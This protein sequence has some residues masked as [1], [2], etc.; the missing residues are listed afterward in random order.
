MAALEGERHVQPG[1]RAQRGDVEPGVHHLDLAVHPEVRGCHLAGA[2]RDDLRLLG[3]IGKQA[4]GQLL[5]VE[6]DL[7]HVFLDAGDG[8][9]LML[10]ALDLHAGHRGPREGAEQRTPQGVPQR[11][12]ETALQRLD[13]KPAVM[14]ALPVFY[15]LDARGDGFCDHALTLQFK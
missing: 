11:L 2:F 1:A 8:G 4:D 10:D 12:A 13:L 14:I 15:A 9:K 7:G 3:G 6:D 5:E